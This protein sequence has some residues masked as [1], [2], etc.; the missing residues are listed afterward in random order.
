MTP[1][2]IICSST[3]LRKWNN[4]AHK[5][6]DLEIRSIKSCRLMSRKWKL[7]LIIKHEAKMK[8]RNL[9]NPDPQDIFLILYKRE[10]CLRNVELDLGRSSHTSYSSLW[11]S[12]L[13]KRKSRNL[14][15]GVKSLAPTMITILLKAQQMKMAEMKNLHQMLSLKEQV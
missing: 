15:F 2:L 8:R 10:N 12:F 5:K 1:M 14:D 7:F 4:R 3:I 6:L 11:K 9:P 13:S